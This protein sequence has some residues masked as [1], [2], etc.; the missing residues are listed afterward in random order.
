MNTF[1]FLERRINQSISDIY[2]GDFIYMPIEKFNK[3]NGYPKGSYL[4]ILSDKKLEIEEGKLLT[5]NSKHNI[6]NVFFCNLYSYIIA[7]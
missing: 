5:S 7:Y 2:I 4:Q 6:I 1:I 3:E